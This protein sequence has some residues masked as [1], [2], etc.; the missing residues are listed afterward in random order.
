MPLVARVRLLSRGETWLGESRAGVSALAAAA[1][2]DLLV[3]VQLCVLAT[4]T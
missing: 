3:A 1:R 4:C 2:V